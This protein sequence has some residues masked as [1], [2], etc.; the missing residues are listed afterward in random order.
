MTEHY[1]NTSIMQSVPYVL[2]I[3][4]ICKLISCSNHSALF[5]TKYIF[6]KVRY[7]QEIYSDEFSLMHSDNFLQPKTNSK[8]LIIFISTEVKIKN[9]FTI[10]NKATTVYSMSN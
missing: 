2:V 8:M 1:I 6:S 4:L 9:W 3:T 10:E 5:D 7:K